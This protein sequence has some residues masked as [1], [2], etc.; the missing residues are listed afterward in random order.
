MYI[1]FIK[2]VTNL[3]NINQITFVLKFTR[4]FAINDSNFQLT[5]IN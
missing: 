5:T 2:L 1:S 3:Y 4:I